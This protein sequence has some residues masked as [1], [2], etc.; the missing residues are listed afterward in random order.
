MRE[1]H[2]DLAAVDFPEQC[3]DVAQLHAP[4]AA[5]GQPADI[6]LAVHVSVAQAQVVELEDAGRMPFHD[7]K[8]VDIRDLVSAQ[9][10]NLNQSR[11]RGLFF[12]G[13]K[14]RRRRG[15]AAPP[16]RPGST[17]LL[18]EPLAD[19]FMRNLRFS[20][21]ECAE[22]AA[23]ALRDRVRIPYILLIHRLDGRR[24]A[25][26][27]RRR[28][29]LILQRLAHLAQECQKKGALVY[30]MPPIEGMRAQAC[31]EVSSTESGRRIRSRPASHK[32]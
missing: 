20:V 11:D 12:A 8:R 3:H 25:G 24:I 28:G 7:A 14:A 13:R 18:Y 30:R 19:R 32:S 1:F 9:R 17:G 5:T 6:E 31:R 16:V 22:I 10:V 2:A 27:K 4:V 21:I 26:V 23:P 29:I 15:N